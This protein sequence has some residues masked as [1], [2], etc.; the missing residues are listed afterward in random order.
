[1]VAEYA[2][3]VERGGSKTVEY[4]ITQTPD[5]QFRIRSSGTYYNKRVTSFA[6]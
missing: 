3:V 6:F 4:R 2:L 5:A 1:M